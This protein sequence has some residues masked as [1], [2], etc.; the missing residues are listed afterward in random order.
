VRRSWIGWCVCAAGDTRVA[1]WLLLLDLRGQRLEEGVCD[2]CKK[3]LSGLDVFWSRTNVFFVPRH[4]LHSENERGRSCHH[5]GVWGDCC[6]SCRSK[7]DAFGVRGVHGTSRDPVW[8]RKSPLGSGRRRMVAGRCGRV[9]AG[10]DGR[11]LRQVVPSLAVSAEARGALC[12]RR[13]RP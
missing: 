3:E 13:C 8:A 7:D 12:A 10:V 11:T 5:V 6:H 4:R 2:R 1:I 9:R